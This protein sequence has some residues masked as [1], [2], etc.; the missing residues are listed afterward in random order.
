MRYTEPW[1]AHKIQGCACDEGFTGYDCSNKECPRGDDPMTTG[2]QNEVMM[3][4]CQAD[5]G[6]F[7]FQFRGQRTEAIPYDAGYGTV[8]RL[9]E[10]LS[11]VKDV[12]VT[13][14]NYSM[15]ICGYEQAQTTYLEFMQDFGSLPAARLDQTFLES[16]YR[17]SP[18][19]YMVTQHKLHCPAGGEF[20]RGW[21]FFSYDGK[22][23]DRL[24]YDASE[25]QIAAA[26]NDMPTVKAQSD[27]G[28]ISITVNTT[29]HAVCLKDSSSNTTIKFRSKFGNLYDLEFINS[30][31]YTDPKITNASSHNLTYSSNK[32]TKE[33]LVCSDHGECDYATGTCQCAIAKGTHYEYYWGSSDGY[34]N[35]GRRGDCGHRWGPGGFP[36]T[37]PGN[38]GSGEEPVLCNGH[39]LGS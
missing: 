5:S 22:I 32:G 2:Q 21:F 31:R 14:G 38:V 27:Y 17:G 34:G 35:Q 16:A 29:R 10:K 37:C 19:L 3:I 4:E 30:I 12:K 23:S 6:Y 36:T 24:A 11:S 20:L 33:N 28:N 1:D 18:W 39:G 7:F 8:E 9:I 25:T 15:P 13:F 26:L